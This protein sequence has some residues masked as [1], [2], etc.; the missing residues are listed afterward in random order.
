MLN[1]Y[2]LKDEY[3]K[4]ELT[5]ILAGPVEGKVEPLRLTG[6]SQLTA[7]ASANLLT[8]EVMEE[9]TRCAAY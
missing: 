2:K 3:S 8:A 1:K 7:Q 5:F 9:E 4:I 6:T